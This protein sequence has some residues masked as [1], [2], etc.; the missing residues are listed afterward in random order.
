MSGESLEEELSAL[1]ENQKGLI[2]NLSNAMG[3]I[4]DLETQVESLR[5]ENAYL[6]EEI[7]EQGRLDAM[8]KGIQQNSANDPDKR[9]AVIVQ[10]MFNDA[11]ARGDAGGEPVAEY[12]KESCKTALGGGAKKQDIHYAMTEAVPRNVS[13][14]A[15]E[16]VRTPRG[17]D[18]LNHLRMDLRE[19][20]VEGI[21]IAGHRIR[22]GGE[23]GR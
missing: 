19:G 11:K 16:Y 3:R 17:A 8:L 21:I 23:Y 14:G 18:R 15:V 2:K 6:R 4:S 9:A 10:H 7:E 20:D 12:D 13:S 22:A 1:R 5:E